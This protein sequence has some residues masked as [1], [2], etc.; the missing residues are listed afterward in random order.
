MPQARKTLCFDLD[1]AAALGQLNRWAGE[2]CPL[3]ASA[4]HRDRLAVR[5]AGAQAAVS[6]MHERSGGREME[7][8]PADAWWSDIRDH[9]HEFFTF[10]QAQLDGGECLW[11]L[12]VPDSAPPIS[13]PGEQFIEWGGGLRWWR[14]SAPAAHIRTAAAASG[15]QATLFRAADKSSG[16]FTRLPPP[17]MNIHQRLKQAFDPAGILNPGRLYPEL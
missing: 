14:S 4:W 5:F 1:E 15:G 9:R 13:L 10:A 6:Y 7:S 11:R 2:S 8:G 12:S 3:H 17:A 16:A